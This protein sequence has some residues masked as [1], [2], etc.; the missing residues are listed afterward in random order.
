MH[1]KLY[2]KYL[3]DVHKISCETNF[4]KKYVVEKSAFQTLCVIIFNTL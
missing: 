3:E 2:V 4:T 1:M